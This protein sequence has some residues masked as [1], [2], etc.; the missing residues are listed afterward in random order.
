MY[1]KSVQS[2][3]QDDPSNAPAGLYSTGDVF[4][5]QIST[6]VLKSLRE[7]V[8]VRLSASS[9]AD[10]VRA[11]TSTAEVLARAGMPEF[12]NDVGNMVDILERIKVVDLRAH[13]RWYDEIAMSLEH[14]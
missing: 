7:H 11:T 1:H 3:Y 5:E 12:V 13:S 8:F 4:S 2:Q 6:F 14:A 10:R 9:T